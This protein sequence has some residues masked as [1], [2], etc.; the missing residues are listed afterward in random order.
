MDDLEFRFHEEMLDL[1]WATGKAIGY[2]A[3]YYLRK[4]RKVAEYKLLKNCC[5]R[6]KMMLLD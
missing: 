4:V 2:W 5:N 3:N 1:Y 6:G